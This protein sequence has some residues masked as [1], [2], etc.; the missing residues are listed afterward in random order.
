MD[1]HLVAELRTLVRSV[2]TRPGGGMVDG[3]MLVDGE[4][5]LVSLPVTLWTVQTRRRN[6][7]SGGASLRIPILAGMSVR[8]GGNRGQS[9]QEL[10]SAEP[11][12]QGNVVL[13]DRRLIYLGSLKT[14]EVPLGRVIGVHLDGASGV[15]V[16]HV[17]RRKSPLILQPEKGQA[18]RLAAVIGLARI[19]AAEGVDAADQALG[20]GTAT[21]PS[22]ASVQSSGASARPI[23]PMTWKSN[24]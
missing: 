15:V 23:I 4:H 3:V 18:E 20:Q 21:Q 9:E 14:D 5:A 24:P 8:V 19:I 11:S 22:S 16:A 17:S 1:T 7:R 13:T 2:R 10:P 6:F 12:D